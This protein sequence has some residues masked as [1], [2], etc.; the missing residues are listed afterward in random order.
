MTLE[1]RHE[2][3]DALMTVLSEEH[4]EG[5]IEHRKPPSIE[6]LRELFAY[7]VQT[8]ELRRLVSVSHNAQSGSVA[9]CQRPDG[10]LVVSVDGRLFL[11][12]RVAW[13]IETGAWPTAFVDHANEDKSD[14]RWANLRE[15]T[16]S[17][18]MHNIKLKAANKSGARGVSRH[19]RSGRWQSHIRINGKSTYLG[20]YDTVE[21]ASAA[22]EAASERAFGEFGGSR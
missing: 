10:Y 14:N 12:H 9:G 2:I 21:E 15:A 1:H 13:A 3:L 20:R 4:A 5:V 17:Q 18:N 22:Y 11:V 8:G 19:S 16:N 6:R 7:N